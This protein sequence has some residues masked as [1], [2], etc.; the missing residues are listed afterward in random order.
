[1]RRSPKY[2]G[3]SSKPIH[4]YG[5]FAQW[6][7]LSLGILT[8]LIIFSQINKEVINPFL[9][10]HPP[11]QTPPNTSIFSIT[12]LV[13]PIHR[14]P[15]ASE[16]S[17]SG[18][19][20]VNFDKVDFDG[21][22]IPYTGTS[23]ARLAKILSQRVIT[24][25]DKARIA[26]AW[27]THN[28]RYDVQVFLT[29]NYQV[30]SAEDVLRERQA[31]CSGYAILYEALTRAMG[32]ETVTIV[33]RAKGID[34]GIEETSE[35]NHAWNATKIDGI[36]Y[37]I[38]TTWGAGILQGDVFH[39]EFNSFYFAPEPEHIIYSHFPEVAD[40]QLLPQ[41]ITQ[42][43]FEQFPLLKSRF[44]DQGL[45]LIQPQVYIVNLRQVNEITLHVP[46]GIDVIAN[47]QPI[48]P[49]TH[50]E[51]QLPVNILRSQQDVRIPLVDMGQDYEVIIFTKPENIA[52]SYW[53]AAIFKVQ[54]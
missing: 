46:S 2:R 20:Q 45:Q 9:S 40:W 39:P 44:F 22:H 25:Q 13:Y 52:G 28:I 6:L 3:Q 26:Y 29:K 31:I 19:S 50:Q 51:N 37:L 24:E 12:P 14:V 8:I 1:M 4:R 15:K 48:H 7:S 16:I 49:S 42:E 32:L 11:G 21:Q 10:T 18:L 17:G 53:S 33:G 23:V 38:D 36:W 41:K 5:I 35:S 47:Y 27:I 54:S 43:A 30:V 34:Y